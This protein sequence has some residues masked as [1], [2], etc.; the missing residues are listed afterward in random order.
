MAID[1]STSP[2]PATQSE[3]K[4]PGEQKVSWAELFLDLVWV[5]AVTQIAGTLAGAT[6]WGDVARTLLLLAPLWW[7]WIGVT[8]L[9][10][11]AGARLDSVR[12]R[13]LIFV[14][15]GCGLGMAVTVPQAWAD[16][17]MVFA[18]SYT[19]L[20]LLL[21]LGMRRQPTFGGLRLE[22]YAVS[23]FASGPL[24][25]IGAMFAGSWRTAIWAV[26][27]MIGIFSPYLLR[28]R[29]DHVRFETSHL[30][31]RFGLFLIIALGE[32]VVAVGGQA[33]S[34]GL[35]LA[36]VAALA[37]SF[38]VIIGLW[39]TYFH[40]GAPAARHSLSTDPRQS[41][42]ARDVFSYAHFLYVA[43]IICVA[44]GLKKTLAHPVDV[45]HKVT[46]LLLAPGVGLYLAGFC[47]ARWRMFGAAGLSRFVAAFGCFAIAAVAP[48][49]PQLAVAAMIAAVLLAL[50]VFE[51]WRVET[52]RTILLLQ[53]PWQH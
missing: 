28:R 25:L 30:P 20:R 32:T 37:L 11:A 26:A 53:L 49:L 2:A 10:N 24:F 7:G 27:A 31:E 15:A 36:A 21:W 4:V 34:G 9:G 33:A 47:Y 52:G 17:G 48:L 40:Y 44:V 35:D 29:L 18:V 43:A 3:Q 39:W 12:G 22:P 14:M 5:F 13:A 42:I 45:P 46:E 51:A 23:L 41:R 1:Q 6:G 16:R 8:L 50:N 19:V 38:V